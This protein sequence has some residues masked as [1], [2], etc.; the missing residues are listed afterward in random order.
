MKIDHVAAEMLTPVG[1]DAVVRLPGRRFPGIVVQGNTLSSLFS[2]VRMISERAKHCGDEELL[3]EAAML[4]ERF[5][6][7]VERYETALTSH[8]IELPYAKT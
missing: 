2:S 6:A 3:D 4:L 1:N 5:A 7:M 8:G